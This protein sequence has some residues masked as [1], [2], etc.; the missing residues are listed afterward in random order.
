MNKPRDFELALWDCKAVRS[1]EDVER[2]VKCIAQAGY[3]PSAGAWTREGNTPSPIPMA[4]LTTQVSAAHRLTPAGQR[5]A[6]GGSSSPILD[7]EF[8]RFPMIWPEQPWTYG[9]LTISRRIGGEWNALVLVGISSFSGSD[10][11][12]SA[13]CCSW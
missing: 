8:W 7:A 10:D 6:E 5:V 1:T 2:L 12:F 11:E 3:L 4:E 13:L 9:T